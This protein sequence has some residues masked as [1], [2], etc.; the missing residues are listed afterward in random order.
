MARASVQDLKQA[1]D[2]LPDKPD[3]RF[4]RKPETGLAMVRGRAGNT[5]TRFNLGEM[6]ITR[7]AVQIERGN[8]GIGYVSGRDTKKAEL[9][10]LFD[11]LLQDEHHQSLLWERL[12][13]PLEEAQAAGKK[14]KAREAAATKVN[15]FTMV[16]GED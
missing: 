5:G 3:Y 16:R 15:F 8:M 1:W 14:K 9:V 10:A 2:N 11:A 12:I 6:T 13:L 7:C 4:L